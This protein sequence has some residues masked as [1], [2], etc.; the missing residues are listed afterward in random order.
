MKKTIISIACVLAVLLAFAG[1]GLWWFQA[2]YMPMVFAED[3]V[4]VL[5]YAA[6]DMFLRNPTATQDE[7]DD[8]INSQHEASNINLQIDANGKAVDPFGT[9]FRVEHLVLS[10]NSITTV[11]SAGP[12]RE[13]GTADDITFKHERRMEPQ[14]SAAGD[15]EDRAP[16][17]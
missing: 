10:S 1:T 7:I 14:P 15:A 9:P 3:A 16:E 6:S 2:R 5:T 4:Q 8:M 13:F 12:D 11:T 17:P